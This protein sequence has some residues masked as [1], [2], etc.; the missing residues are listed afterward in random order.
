MS[1]EWTGGQ[2]SVYRVLLGLTLLLAFV[3]LPVSPATAF[4]QAVA[5]P[6]PNLGQLLAES[7]PGMGMIYAAVGVLL[8][9]LLVLGKWDRVSAWILAFMLP[10]PP[11]QVFLISPLHV[12]L[13]LHLFTPAAPYGSLSA[14]GR[15]N[16]GG[17]WQ[18][19]SRIPAIVWL[20]LYAYCLSEGM[21]IFDEP[22]SLQWSTLLA[23]VQVLF[24][25]F[26]LWS[27]SR[28][29]AWLGL[30]LALWVLVFTG[31][32]VWSLI[33]VLCL[34]F[35]PA[36]LREAEQEAPE[37]MFYD[38]YCGLCHRAVR[39][40][41]AEDTK[42]SRFQF[43]PLQSE[44]FASMVPEDQRKALPDSVVV[45]SRDGH[46]TTR[47]QAIV[48]ILRRL[49]GGWTLAGWVLALIPRLL[50]D[51]GYDA[52][53]AIRYRIFGKPDEVCPLVPKELRPRFKF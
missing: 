35:D 36:W 26:S 23:L 44:I 29:F 25:P 2:Y 41:L 16:P 27:R 14:W 46:L 48:L 12:L 28:P 18:M 10:W 24:V 32:P 31:T 13:I 51:W 9:F 34:A 50:R 7:M 5:G 39:F 38:G 45:I 20:L 3:R 33:V 40:V 43:A 30:W 37:W 17:T 53:A 1:R 42:G 11:S 47:S 4:A 6:V 15:P 22:L 8:S 21:L 19:P 49:G 52:I